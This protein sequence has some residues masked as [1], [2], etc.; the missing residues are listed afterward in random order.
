MQSANLLVSF[1]AWNRQTL[2]HCFVAFMFSFVHL[3]D[4][5]LG[6]ESFPYLIFANY[7]GL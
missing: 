1:T 7:S 6:I 5:V 4:C 3:P 2:E